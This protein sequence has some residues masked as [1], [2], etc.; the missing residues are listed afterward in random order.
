MVRDGES[1]SRP[2]WPTVR[3]FTHFSEAIN[4]IIDARVWAGIHFRHADEEGE[5]IGIRI[6]NFRQ[7][8]YFQPVD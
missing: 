6:A 7:R 3:S 4:E 1:T 5:T 2:T 8:N